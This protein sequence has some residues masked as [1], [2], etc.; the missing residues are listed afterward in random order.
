[1]AELTAERSLR[2]PYGATARAGFVVLGL[3]I[4]GHAV[5]ETARDTLF[6]TH[7]PPSRLPVLYLVM[8]AATLLVARNP[9]WV[10]RSLR[11]RRELSVALAAS[12]LLTAALWPFVG[13]SGRWPLYALYLWTG[14][15]AS[16]VV[17]QLWLLLDEHF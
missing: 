16:L 1:M 9:H 11:G 12:A 13:G 4:A 8:A 15:Y 5:L 6:L 17:V 7:L 2:E 14:L 10:Q 3:M